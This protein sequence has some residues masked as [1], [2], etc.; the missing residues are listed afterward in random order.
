MLKI[1][2]VFQYEN[3]GE[4]HQFLISVTDEAAV[5]ETTHRN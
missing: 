3:T 5:S 4:T 2:I 1:I